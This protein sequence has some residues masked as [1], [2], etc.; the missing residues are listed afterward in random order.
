[1]ATDPP[2]PADTRLIDILQQRDGMLTTLRLINGTENVV[3]DIAWGY[4]LGDEYAHITTNVSPG[5]DGLPID[6]F[7]SDAVIGLADTVTGEV[8]PLKVI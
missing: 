4:D 3:K 7:Y 2:N 8:I 1:V 5:G 6:F